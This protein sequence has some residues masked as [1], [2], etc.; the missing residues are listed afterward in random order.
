MHPFRRPARPIRFRSP[1]SP[2]RK[3][4]NLATG[5]LLRF[6]THANPCTRNAFLL[7]LIQTPRGGMALPVPNPHSLAL[8]F[9]L[10]PFAAIH[11]LF[12]Q[13]LAHSLQIHRGCTPER[14]PASRAPARSYARHYSSA[15]T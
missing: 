1:R 14:F 15:P 2:S 11:L 3:R 6:H 8:S 5:N 13:L 12:F 9:T 7:I 4:A 10:L